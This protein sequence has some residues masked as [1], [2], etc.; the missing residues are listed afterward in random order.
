MVDN[1]IVTVIVF[2]FLI[3]PSVC[4]VIF[5]VFTCTKLD[6]AFYLQVRACTSASAEPRPSPQAPHHTKPHFN[7]AEGP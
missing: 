7:K 1:F 4:R 6:D 5:E 3:Y 2:L